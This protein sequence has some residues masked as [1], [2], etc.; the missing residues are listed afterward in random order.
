MDAIVYNIGKLCADNIFDLHI[1]VVHGMEDTM[2]WHNV[3]HAIDEFNRV[4][5]A[6]PIKLNLIGPSD[7]FASVE[8]RFCDVAQRKLIG[9]IIPAEGFSSEELTLLF[10][11]CNRFHLPCLTTNDRLLNFSSNLNSSSKPC[12][13]LDENFFVHSVAPSTGR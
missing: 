10:S 13:S 2:A 12:L 5:A 9:L 3:K 8:E 7:P 1:G 6:F 4:F 11:I